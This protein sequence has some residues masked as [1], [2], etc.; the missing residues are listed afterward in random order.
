MEKNKIFINCGNDF[1]TE[2][3]EN[4]CEHLENGITVRVATDCIGHSLNNAVQESYKNALLTKY[5][6]KLAISINNGV[7]RYSYNYVLR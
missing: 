5:G 3:F 7:C 1:C 2:N 4:L 6:N